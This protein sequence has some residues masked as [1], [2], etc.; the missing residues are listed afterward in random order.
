MI[1]PI[2]VV[3]STVPSIACTHVSHLPAQHNPQHNSDRGRSIRTHHDRV[4][5]M[6]WPMSSGLPVWSVPK[7]W[8]LHTSRTLVVLKPAK[9]GSLALL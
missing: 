7:L 8:S 6:N 3:G 1:M 4:L 2:L 9:F 5:S